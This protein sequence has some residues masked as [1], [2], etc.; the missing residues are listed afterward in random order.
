VSRTGDPTSADHKRIAVGKITRVHGTNGEVAVLV[1]SEVEGRFAD[2]STLFLDDG[3]EVTVEKTRRDRGRLLVT[4]AGIADRN[5]AKAIQG[6]YL[7][8]GDSELPEL[9]EGHY[10]PFQ[11]EGCEVLTESGRSL[12]TIREIMHTEA[13]DVWAADADGVETLIPALRDVVVSVDVSARRVVVREIPG[14]T[15]P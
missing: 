11:L 3:R 2:R 4:F 1:L 6:K 10:W 9:P 7:L 8:I 14:L 12:G 15:Q 13:N 5:Q